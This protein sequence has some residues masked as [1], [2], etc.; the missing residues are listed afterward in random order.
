VN[1]SDIA[2][3]SLSVAQFPD[4]IRALLSDSDVKEVFGHDGDGMPL[5]LATLGPILE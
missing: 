3:Q 2:D 5:T 1:W 4:S